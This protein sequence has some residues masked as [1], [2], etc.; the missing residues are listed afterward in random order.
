M[1]CPYCHDPVHTPESHLPADARTPALVVGQTVTARRHV[2]GVCRQDEPG[3]V[4]EK[5][6]LGGRPGWT[7]QFQDGGLDGWNPCEAGL[8]LKA[9]PVVPDLADYRFLSVMVVGADLRDGLFDEAFDV[10]YEAELEA[11]TVGLGG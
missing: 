7:V 5:Y 2:T 8:H 6:E 10:A 11:V 9:G 4:V 3:V 1:F